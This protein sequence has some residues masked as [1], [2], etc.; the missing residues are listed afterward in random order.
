MLGALALIVVAQAPQKTPNF[1]EM[2][3]GS[4]GCF[5][6]RE[7]RTGQEIIHN[8]NRAKT[9]FPPCSTFK[10]PHT[11]F[12]LDSGVVDDDAL[13]RWDG[14]PKRMKGWERDFTLKTALEHSALWVFE[15]VAAR[16]GRQRSENDVQRL[17]YGNRDLSGWPGAY[18]LMSSLKISAWEQVD[19]L[20]GFVREDWPF[21]LAAMRHTKAW[22]LVESGDGFKMYAKTGSGIEG[23]AKGKPSP[24]SVPKTKVPNQLGWY[25]GWL[26]RGA[27]TWVFAANYRAPNAMGHRLAP[28]VRNGFVEMGLL[29]KA[30]K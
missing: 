24:T 20:S 12:A 26:E 21:S 19:L 25:V 10:I 8:P 5:L 9:R 2:F 27:D 1:A 16:L 18:W 13:F 7:L 17:G 15:E 30:A 6:A 28:K 11:V 22:L 29:P 3:K 14:Q 4:A 23:E